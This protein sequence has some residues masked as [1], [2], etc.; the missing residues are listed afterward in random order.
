MKRIENKP[1]R[2]TLTDMSTKWMLDV[3]DVRRKRQNDFFQFYSFSL[4]K[5]THCTFRMWCRVLEI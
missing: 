4:K 3:R 1:Q 5:K 2:S